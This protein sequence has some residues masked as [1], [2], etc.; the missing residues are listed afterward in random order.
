MGLPGSA[1]GGGTTGIGNTG[2][3]GRMGRWPGRGGGPPGEGARRDERA[4]F[5]DARQCNASAGGHREWVHRDE[6]LP[7]ERRSERQYLA[8]GP[9]LPDDLAHQAHPYA[10]AA[11]ADERHRLAVA[12]VHRDE[13]AWA[14]RAAAR[15]PGPEM[16]WQRAQPLEALELQERQDA[17]VQALPVAAP[18]RAAREPESEMALEPG[19]PQVELEQRFLVHWEERAEPLGEQEEQPAQQPKLRAQE[20]AARQAAQAARRAQRA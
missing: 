19:R 14:Q 8:P 6:A 3:P 18:Q 7:Q 2:L 10:G 9:E 1:F 16:A 12:R 17:Q 11:S 20:P 4:C 5:R 15:D 13:R